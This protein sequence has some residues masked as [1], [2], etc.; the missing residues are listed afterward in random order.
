MARGYIFEVAEE[1]DDLLNITADHFYERLSEFHV[2]YVSDEIDVDVVTQ[3]FLEMLQ[4]YG[5]SVDFAEKSFVVTTDGKMQ[6]FRSRFAAVQKM[7]TEMTLLTFATSELYSLRSL[8][9]DDYSDIVCDPNGMC[10]DVDCW[11]RIADT[12]KYYIGGVVLMH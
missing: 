7:I 11:I 6:Y 10:H 4:Q 1:K 5:F 2:D 12:H 8:I 3:N 9:Q